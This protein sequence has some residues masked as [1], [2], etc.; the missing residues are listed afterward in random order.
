M[1]VAEAAQRLEVSAGL[2]YALCAA[3]KLRHSRVGLGRGCIR[4]P[5]DA[6]R[7]YLDRCM[8]GARPAVPAP[9]PAARL[10]ELTHLRLNRGRRT[11]SS[12]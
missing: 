10:P 6:I 11:S 5:E 2:V 3:G 8:V 7:E 4:I 9:A 1:R 12:P